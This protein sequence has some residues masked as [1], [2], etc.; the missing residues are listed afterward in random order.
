[1]TA[2][3]EQVL[4]SCAEDLDVGILILAARNLI[5]A[6]LH[7]SVTRSEVRSDDP[8]LL[9]YL[10][11]K[12][13]GKAHEELHAIFVDRDLGFIREEL[14]AVGGQSAVESRIRPL[15]TRS[16]ELGA[17][18]FYLA[19][20]HPSQHPNPSCEDVRS[21]L[22]LAQIVKAV[23]LVIFDHF[24]VAGNSVASMRGLGLL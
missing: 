11:L 5:H 6:A 9:N 15:L 2:T 3:D 14:V 22:A 1:M 12:M 20:N 24:I 18:G 21:T 7:E 13:R 10:I 16:L 8:A 17:A 4:K 19:H 23:D